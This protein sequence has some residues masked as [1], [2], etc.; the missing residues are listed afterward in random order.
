MSNL[1]F[2][3][4]LLCLVCYTLADPPQPTSS[5]PFNNF[6]LFL[7]PDDD[8]T[9]TS[10]FSPISKT[11]V[12]SQGKVHPP[13]SSTPQTSVTPFHHG[14]YTDRITFEFSHP[15]YLTY[16]LQPPL[17]KS[18]NSTIATP[19]TL[20]FHFDHPQHTGSFSIVY[21]CHQ[22]DHFNNVS[23]SVV[24][25]ILP[26]LSIYFSF[27]KTCPSG[28][29]PY[30]N[31][32][33]FHPS[34]HAPSDSVPVPFRPNSL[35]PTFG[36]HIINTRIYLKLEPPA[37]SQEFF[38]I[39][40]TTSNPALSAQVRGPVF[41]GVIRT[42]ESPVIHVLYHCHSSGLFDVHLRIPIWP[43]DELT[44]SWKKDC[45]GGL[46][47]GLNVASSRSQVDDVVKAA[48]TVE[49]WKMALLMT[50]DGMGDRA[51]LVNASTRVKD[52]WMHNGGVAVHVAPPVVTV[53]RQEVGT[54]FASVVERPDAGFDAESGGVLV[55]G[56]RLGIRIRMVCKRRGRTVVV[57]TFPVRAF[58]NV[59]FGFVKICRT[60]KR[61]GRFGSLKTAKSLTRFT[62][63]VLA[64]GLAYWWVVQ[65]RKIGMG[66]K[67]RMSMEGDYARVPA[68]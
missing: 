24:F 30:I 47:K 13:W 52:F 10:L 45:G 49:K 51:P 14:P 44:A 36:P 55:T 66:G 61:Y 64:A 1:I 6:H 27:T 46:A 37:T 25:P 18:S 12:F 17:P 57:V 42:S 23:I 15:A 41:G 26:A 3:L 56:G 59:E 5:Q 58:V 62:S 33:Y 40:T 48:E 60:P 4:L 9:H 20:D 38:H 11:T 21:D 29:H 32:G 8:D 63:F 16:D 43:F 54:A 35:I 68:A 50:S 22:L 39:N 2:H 19:K 34:P 65:L 53:E 7:S 28:P 31:F 67:K